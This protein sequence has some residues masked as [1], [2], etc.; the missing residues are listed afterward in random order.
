MTIEEIERYLSLKNTCLNHDVYEE[1]EKLRLSAIDSLN[2]EKANYYWC[3]KQI[4]TIQNEFVS[5][6]HNMK[7]KKYEEAWLALDRADIDLG[8]LAENFDVRKDNDKYHLVFIGEIIK[9][10]QKLFPYRYFLSRENIIKAEKCSICGKP[11]SLRKSCGHKVGKLYMGEL[12]I[13]IVTDMEFVGASVVTDPFDK[14]GFIKIDGQEYNYGMIDEFI[15]QIKNPY[16]KFTIKTF[17]VKNPMYKNIGR[18]ELC[19]CG[20]GKKYKKCH[21][22]TQDE[23][24]DHNIV[25]FSSA[26]SRKTEF[27]GNFNTWK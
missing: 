18:N 17:K 13:R 27:I 5:S 21:R 16:D 25:C 1:I 2:E 10:Y 14:Y 11:S 8:I 9:E 15:A 19:P 6:I 20:S 26:N 4:Y 12:C 24:M 23:L 3:L 22:D 7:N